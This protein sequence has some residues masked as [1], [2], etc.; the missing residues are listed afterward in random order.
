MK[1]EGFEEN[2]THLGSAGS[3]G[4]LPERKETQMK[5]KI[6]FYGKC[7]N[8]GY[9]GPLNADEVGAPPFS[10]PGSDDPCMW[11]LVCPECE[12]ANIEDVGQDVDVA[13]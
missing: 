8:C 13:D 9:S 1:M 3:R 4:G 7:T 11:V 5:P 10:K 6:T 2:P 12:S